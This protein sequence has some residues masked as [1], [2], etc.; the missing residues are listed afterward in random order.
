MDHPKM[1]STTQ[2]RNW[3]SNGGG[4]CPFCQSELIKYVGTYRAI[5]GVTTLK[6]FCQKCQR[7]HYAIYSGDELVDL[8]HDEINFDMDS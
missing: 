4:W 6:Y 1:L 3:V 7:I 8:T 2:V 5:N